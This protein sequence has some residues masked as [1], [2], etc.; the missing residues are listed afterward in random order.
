MGLA[1]KQRQG[2]TT[3]AGTFDFRIEE[4]KE[5]IAVRNWKF[6]SFLDGNKLRQDLGGEIISQTQCLNCE[7]EGQYIYY[8]PM[9]ANWGPRPSFN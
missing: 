9:T 6:R 5:K 7:K 3:M 2:I 4:P 1:L 8:H